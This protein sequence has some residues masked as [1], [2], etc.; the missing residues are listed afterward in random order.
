MKCLEIKDAKVCC[1]DE[2]SLGEIML[3][4][5]PG[6]ER[7]RQARSFRVWRAAAS[8]TSRAGCANASA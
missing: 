8:T 3:R 1:W 2:V 5:D 6:E 7:V 4:L